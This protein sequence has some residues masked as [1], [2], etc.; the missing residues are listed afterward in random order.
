MKNI[1]LIILILHS[2]NVFSQKY[3]VHVDLLNIVEDKVPV[4]IRF[5]DFELSDSIEYQ[6]PKI[7]PGTYSISNFGRLV[8]SFSANDAEGKVM[9]VERLD[10]NRWLI[11]NAQILTEINYWVDDTFD[12]KKY[13][14]IFEP[15]GTNFEDENYLLNNFAIVGF[16]EGYEKF[17]YD[18]KV[19]HPKEMYG[20][21]PMEREVNSPTEETFFSNNYLQLTDSPIMYCLPDTASVM[22]GD[23]EVMVSVY[24][25]SGKSNA[26]IMMN[27]IEP[28][29]KA[30]GEYL[31]GDL[32]VKKYV[33]L[34][35]LHSSRTNSGAMGALEHSYSTVFSFPDSQSNWLASSIVSTTSHEFFHIITPLTIHSEEI[36]DYNFIDPEMSKHLWLYE[37]LT[38]YS[39]MRVQVMYDLMSDDAFLEEIVYKMKGSANYNDRLPFTEM[40]KGALDIYEDQYLN[41]YEKGALIGMCLDLLLLNV[42]DGDYDVRELM[43]ELSLTYGVD[44]SFKDDELFEIIAEMSYPETR[45]FFSR[46]V[47]GSEPLPLIEYLNF[48]GANYMTGEVVY[49]NTLGDISIG[50]NPDTEQLTISDIISANSFGKKMGFKEGDILYSMMGQEIN[51]ENYREIFQEFF[52][53]EEG[54]KV[55]VEV[56]RKKNNGKEVKKVLK[57][58][59]EQ[60]ESVRGEYIYWNENPSQK[61]LKLRNLWINAN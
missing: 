13:K 53:L 8:T 51:F 30:Q 22:I 56:L 40:S 16:L 39:S 52:A 37:G 20:A 23:T 60:V 33:I 27:N 43:N 2:L 10:D 4:K 28:T 19:T 49:V 17:P 5:T 14:D 44:R 7:V 9:E 59:V 34:I 36:G 29:L 54:E 25:P 6:L 42:S 38:E 61:Q 3:D 1:S 48:V 46:Y 55:K 32:P 45:E 35:Y 58:K 57:G 31:G 50:F 18:Y 47:E 11:N 15:S 24:S 26:S 41:V 12:D 21:S